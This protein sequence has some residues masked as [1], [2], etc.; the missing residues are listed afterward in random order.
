MS[1]RA[2]AALA[3]MLVALG[4]A[5]LALALGQTGSGK[6][7]LPAV[8]AK[9]LAAVEARIEQ[10][11][12][13]GKPYDAPAEAQA[14]FLFK[15]APDHKSPIPF[16]RYEEAMKHSATMP[17]HSPGSGRTLMR[18]TTAAGN[19]AAWTPLGP[20]NVGGRTRALVVDPGTPTTMYAGAA[21]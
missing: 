18:S 10:T 11:G 1:R 8:L 7:K 20:G 3:T 17:R 6:A 12:R 19:L 5:V 9:K 14:F 13:P 15:R 2:A 16:R 4:A 21:S